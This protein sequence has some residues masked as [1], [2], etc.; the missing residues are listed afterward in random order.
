M[1]SYPVNRWALGRSVAQ[2]EVDG[3]A[4]RVKVGPY[5]A[6][7]EHD[8]CLAVAALLGLPV[9]EVARRAEQAA[10]GTRAGMA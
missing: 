4:V 7:A 2:V 9:A 1:R 8:D 5:R 3:H 6:K 10:T